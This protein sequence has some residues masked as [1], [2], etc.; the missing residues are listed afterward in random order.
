MRSTG[1]WS[2]CDLPPAPLNARAPSPAGQSGYA[3]IAALLAL[4][5]ITLLGLSLAA[6][7]S[8]DLQIATNFRL[9][10]QARYNSEAGVEAAKVL[11]RGMDWSVILPPARGPWVP[12]APSAAPVPPFTRA[13]RNLE[14]GGCDLRG[15]GAGYGVVLDD[16]AAGPFERVSTVLGQRLNGEFTAW[17]RRAVVP[18]GGGTLQDDPSNDVLVLT[19]EGI[20]PAGPT[21][22]GEGRSLREVRLRRQLAGGVYDVIVE[23]QFDNS[24]VC[25]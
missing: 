17:V 19:V 11:L 25:R 8:T 3:L 16:G 12:T 9:A 6:T 22:S 24:P 20:A 7:T 4:L 15:G 23:S 10:H 18:G 5:V 2:I 14:R 1:W 13:T 21:G